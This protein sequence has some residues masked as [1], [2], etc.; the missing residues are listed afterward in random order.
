M[1]GAETDELESAARSVASGE[2]AGGAVAFLA[3]LDPLVWDRGL[4]R[5]LWDFDYIW[6]VYIPAAKRRWGYY[7]LPI[8]AGDRLIGRIEP[9]IDRAAGALRILDL[10]WEDGIE[11]LDEPGLMEGLVD[12]LGALAQ[13]AG[14][15]RV[16]WPRTARQRSVGA[17]VR[18][19][20][21]PGGRVRS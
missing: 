5:S 13:F 19:R 12:A 3:P 18:A 21:G 20:L 14:V 7:V 6:E 8:L 4:L 11:P 2:S 16:V 1:L 10:W 15:G 17:A 9:R